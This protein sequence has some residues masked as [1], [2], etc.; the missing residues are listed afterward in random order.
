MILDGRPVAKDL[1]AQAAQI[2]HGLKRPPRLT[3][4][5]YSEDGN[6][7]IYVSSIAKKARRVGIEVTVRPFSIDAVAEAGRDATVDAIQVQ[8]PVPEGMLMRHV[9]DLIPK[10]KD[11]EGINPHNAASVFHRREGFV[12][13][14]A[15]AVIKILDFYRIQ[16]DGVHAVVVGR[17]DI[18][19]KPISMLLL[20]RNA[21]V[22]VC[23]SKTDDVAFHV[24]NADLLVAATG[25]PNLI[26]AEWIK[27]GATVIDVGV[28]RLNGRIVGDVDRSAELRAANM[29]PVPN[30]IGPVTVSL[31]LLNAARSV[32]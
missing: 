2:V 27:A 31:L 5:Q 12:P 15:E 32:G 23:H 25:K 29:T 3:V 21:T 17:S 7:S 30:G 18:V 11:I 19:G 16:T 20:H 26:S 10:E 14:T 9:G 13:C 28:Y 4:F 22:T 6:S 1:L 8:S 24:K